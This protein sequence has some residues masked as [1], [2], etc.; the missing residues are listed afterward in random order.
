MDPADLFPVKI[1]YLNSLPPQQFSSPP[2]PPPANFP[3][4][5]VK[6]KRGRPRKA[7][8]VSVIDGSY[9]DTLQLPMPSLSEF[10]PR[11]N[12]DDKDREVLNSDGV[13]VDLAALGASEHPYREEIRQRTDGMR[14]EEELLGFLT[15]LNGRWGSRRKKK[16]I[17]D[18]NEF[19]SKLPVGWKLSLSVKK[20]NGNVWLYCRR[21]IRFPFLYL[22]TLHFYVLCFAINWICEGKS[23]IIIVNFVVNGLTTNLGKLSVLFDSRDLL[24]SFHF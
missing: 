9:A 15:G 23:D 18:A 20:K 17:V 4:I 24:L 16:R 6:R 3:S 8:E 11:D 12:A 19:G 10:I 5:G 7:V 14:T 13:A 21:Y 2:S 1:E 22:F